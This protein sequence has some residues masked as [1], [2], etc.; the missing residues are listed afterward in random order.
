MSHWHYEISTTTTQ[1]MW[2]QELAALEA[3]L[4]GVVPALLDSA[5]QGW[6]RNLPHAEQQRQ[7]IAELNFLGMARHDD[8]ATMAAICAI[9]TRRFP[10]WWAAHCANDPKEWL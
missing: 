4:E 7:L 5:D 6:L 9:V 2:L 3:R 8:H 10:A 1:G